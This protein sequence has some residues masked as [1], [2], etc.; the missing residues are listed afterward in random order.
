MS[1]DTHDYCWQM[2]PWFV[3]GRLSAS[4][5]QRVERH[6]EECAACREELA[7]QRALSLHVR[8]DEPLL[9]APQS[10]L[11]KMMARIDA[12]M[13]VSG[14]IDDESLT[15]TSEPPRRSGRSRSYRWLA[16]A[17]GIQAVAIA[18]LLTLVLRQT[19]DEITAP[20]F[21]TLSSPSAASGPG[22]MFRVVFKPETSA[23]QIQ[24]L[25]HSV[26]AQVIAGP[27][28]AGVYTLRLSEA[29]DADAVQKLSQVRADGSVIFAERLAPERKP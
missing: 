22:A 20:R 29:P 19:T 12:S 11:Q 15:T 27:S 14:Q 10:S 4:D 24:A 1:H 25:L 13:P 7:E 18:A 21:S 2:M 28:E 8:R 6:L 26:K 17:A 23:A 5:A 16:I 3:T 9:L